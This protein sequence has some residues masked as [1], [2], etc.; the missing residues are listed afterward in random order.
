VNTA[1]G[2]IIDIDALHDAMKDNVVLAAGLDVLPQEPANVQ[3]PLIRAWHAEEAWI[4]HRL[5]LTPH[6]AFF[7]PESARD[8][9][10]IA[11][12]TAARYLRDGR[13]ENCVNEKFLTARR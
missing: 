4:R 7:T 3:A 12:R 10:A 6:S 13:L 11:A 8:M 1:R 2:A 5:L 9:R